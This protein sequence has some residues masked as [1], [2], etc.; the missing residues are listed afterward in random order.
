M[1]VASHGSSSAPSPAATRKDGPY[2][3]HRDPQILLLVVIV[4]GTFAVMAG[5][6]NTGPPFG[7]DNETNGPVFPVWDYDGEKRPDAEAL[8]L[9]ANRT[10]VDPGGAVQFTVTA[11]DKPVANATVAVAGEQVTTDRNGT[12]VRTFA[13]PGSY[14]VTVAQTEQTAASVERVTV[15]VRKYR[16]ELAVSADTSTPVTGQ[17]VPVTVTRAD[18]GEPVAGTVAVGPKTYEA[19]ETG[20]ATVR[21]ETAGSHTVGATKEATETERFERATTAVSVDRRTV[22]LSVELDSNRTRVGESVTVTV[23]RSD[24]GDAVNA[25]VTAG[26]E[27]LVTGP[28]G[29]ANLSLPLSGTYDVRATAAQTPAVEFT[30]ATATLDVRPRL[31]GLELSVTPD[32]APEGE[33]VTFVLRRADTGDPVSGT[34]VLYGTPYVT[35]A[36]GRLR[37]AFQTPATVSAVGQKAENRTTRY[38]STTREFTVE[39]AEYTVSALDAPEF[40]QAGENVTMNATVT[41]DGNVRE[42][43]TV[44]YS[45]GNHSLAT[46]SV[47]LAPG[48]SARVTL[49]GELPSLAPGTY[50]QRVTAEEGEASST[51]EVGEN[52]SLANGKRRL[53]DGLHGLSVVSTA[54]D[55]AVLFGG[56]TPP[57][58][59]SSRT[60]R[61]F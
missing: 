52:E 29:T 47:S 51:I 46:T 56:G 39:G 44:R 54:S 32:P 38:R 48:E 20:V 17:A 30:A 7:D 40:A 41:N 42:S 31:V 59:V 35:D 36:E 24:T 61:S 33:R 19:N 53:I 4:L 22:P 6:L 1:Q 25:T 15:R 2:K 18:T 13:D 50:D 12:V 58:T 55:F 27:T 45:V 8:E 26:N 28:D 14:E 10:T 49:T 57:V 9:S 16:V 34:V 3:P 43:T 23:V 21:F 37:V 60:E 5:G 11:K